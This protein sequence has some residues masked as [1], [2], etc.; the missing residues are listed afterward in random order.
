LF[1]DRARMGK[2]REFVQLGH[3]SPLKT[4]EVTR[5]GFFFAQDLCT[6]ARA[7]NDGKTTGGL[8]KGYYCRRS[9]RK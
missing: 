1:A 4:T 6:L 9:T 3:G 8:R 5:C 7:R 2:K